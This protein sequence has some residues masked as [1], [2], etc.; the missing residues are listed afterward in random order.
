MAEAPARGDAE[1]GL[2]PGSPR[3]GIIPTSKK[4]SGLPAGSRSHGR[5]GSSV[6]DRA[7]PHRRRLFFTGGVGVAAPRA[8]GAARGGA[9]WGPSAPPVPCRPPHPDRVRWAACSR[10][11][12]P[13]RRGEQ[14]LR[15]VTQLKENGQVLQSL[16]NLWDQYLCNVRVVGLNICYRIKYFCA[17]LVTSLASSAWGCR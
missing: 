4:T 15:R 16:F 13:Y 2:S 6:E 8:I 1:N 5:D 3:Q 17:A 9:G 12:G 10:S 11:G 14:T 7:A